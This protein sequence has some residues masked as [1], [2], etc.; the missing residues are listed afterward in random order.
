LNLAFYLLKENSNERI[1]LGRTLHSLTKQSFNLTK[2]LIP[3]S[4]QKIAMF[5]ADGEVGRHLAEEALKRGHSVTAIVCDEKEF[6]LKHPNLKVVKAVT[7]KKEEVSK[8][9]KGHDVV[10]S[11]HEPSREKPREHVEATRAYIEG[12]KMAGVPHLVTVGH[13]FGKWTG[14]NQ[15]SYEAY[16][17]IAQAQR[18][19]LSLFRKEKD[20]N[21]SYVRGQ[22]PVRR[23]DNGKYQ[24]G[25]EILF[26]HPEG[27]SK[28]KPQNFAEAILDEAEKSTPEFHG[29]EEEE[30]L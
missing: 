1:F 8:Y 17:P 30:E 2:I 16:K 24:M 3:M 22:E 25:G 14:N 7:G 20:L 29:F 5:G 6:K 23:E 11:F 4:T 21:W 12:T 28:V 27:E 18:D 26:A 13:A 9:A 19:A 15:E 10:I